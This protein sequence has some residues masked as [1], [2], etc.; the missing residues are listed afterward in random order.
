MKK[1]I[2]FLVLFVCFTSISF[3]EETNEINAGSPLCPVV[4][5]AVSEELVSVNIDARLA[6]LTKQRDQM[7]EASKK[8]TMERQQIEANF[9]ALSGALL[10]LEDM[11]KESQKK[12]DN[13]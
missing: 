2:C 8:N 7:V 10:V 12:V 6:N 5:A 9:A 4:P 3:A 11:K 1:A 13:K